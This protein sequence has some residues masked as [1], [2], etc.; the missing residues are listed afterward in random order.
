[1]N[2]FIITVGLLGGWV[3][4]LAR[5]PTFIAFIDLQQLYVRVRRKCR[6]H[7]WACEWKGMHGGVAVFVVSGKALI[8]K[9]NPTFF[10]VPIR[11][12]LDQHADQLTPDNQFG[13]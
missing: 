7:G 9:P 3:Y 1:M 12:I 5:I 6:R 13:A 10:F 2:N 8:L 4:L 11:R